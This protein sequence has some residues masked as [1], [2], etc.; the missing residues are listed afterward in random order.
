MKTSMRIALLMVSLA[1][2]LVSGCT[3]KGSW[4]KLN[5][6]AVSLY[7]QGLYAKA[8]KVAEKALRVAEEEFGSEHT[9]VGTSLNN[10]AEIYGAQG[11]HTEAEP[12]YRRALAIWEKTLG[13]DH[14]NVGIVLENLAELCK[15]LGKKDEA[16]RL[17]ERAGRIRLS[18]P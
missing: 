1:S 5:I 15:E 9:N 18:N 11:R 17:E 10:L 6:K 8:A 7:E 12:L 2:C 13:E 3:Q 14:P 4:D 16:R